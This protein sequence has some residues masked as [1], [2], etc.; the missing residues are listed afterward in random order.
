LREIARRSGGKDAADAKRKYEDKQ[1]ELKLAKDRKD[2]EEDARAKAAIK[3]KI[4]QDKRERAA[5][6]AARQAKAAGNVAPSTA[7]AAAATTAAPA[8]KKEYTQALIQLRFPDGTVQKVKFS[9]TDTLDAVLEQAGML[10]G[11]H[12]IS[13]VSNFPKK[14]YNKS[15]GDVQKVTLQQADLVPTGTLIVSRR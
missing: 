15:E 7:P 3:A 11:D 14:V 12:N 2:R 4:D 10:F 9:P 13:L 6:A 8:E 1:M 5:E